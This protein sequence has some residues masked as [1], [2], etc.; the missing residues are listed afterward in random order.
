MFTARRRRR[1][2]TVCKYKFI[3]KKIKFRASTDTWSILY[4]G[5]HPS[6]Y[7]WF[8]APSSPSV[9]TNVLSTP[10]ALIDAAVARDF[11]IWRNQRCRHF[12]PK[13]RKAKIRYVHCNEYEGAS[14]K[15]KSANLKETKTNEEREGTI[16]KY[17]ENGNK[18]TSSVWIGMLR[19]KETSSVWIEIWKAITK[20]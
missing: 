14:G 17:Y 18:R 11:L 20:R 2:G 3:W 5:A 13:Y 6:V 16:R 1:D 7:F 8:T 15:P 12:H 19:D 4:S 9:V 10:Y